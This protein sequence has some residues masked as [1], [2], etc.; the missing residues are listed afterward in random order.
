MQQTCRMFAFL[1]ILG[2][3]PGFRAAAKD[4]PENNPAGWGYV[5]DRNVDVVS[6]P[7]QQKADLVLRPGALVG[8]WKWQNKQGTR[9]AQIH[10]VNL[11]NFKPVDGW[12]DASLIEEQPLEKSPSDAELRGMIGGEFL[13]DYTASHTRIT[14]FLVPRGNASPTLICF[15]TSPLVPSARLVAFLS[16]SGKLVPG[17]A[18]EFPAAD[19]NPGV[20]SVEVRDL[21]GDGNECLITR[22]PFRL[23]PETR[24]AYQVIRRFEGSQFRTLWKA[25][26]EFRNLDAYPA[27]LTILQPPEKNIGQPGTVT[28]G[29]VTFRQHGSLYEPVWKGKVEFHVVGREEAVET[30]PLE[31]ICPWD[32]ESFLP[33]Q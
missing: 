29:E 17:P 13:D 3:Y 26:V 33:L 7:G 12:V 23:G 10:V 6:R 30:V 15:V 2:L 5:R 9:W 14:R 8:L 27:R 31:K 24:G 4:A 21:L 25:P 18:L 32:G 11:E 16:D 19:M 20:A 1:I 22:E 28:K